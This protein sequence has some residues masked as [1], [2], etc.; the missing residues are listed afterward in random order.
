MQSKW[1]YTLVPGLLLG[2]TGCPDITV[3][4]DEVGT[5][6]PIVEFDPGNRIVPFPNNLLLDPTTGKVN[7]PASCNESPASMATRTMVLN[8]LDGFGTYQTAMSVTFSE[9][10]DAATLADHVV[11]YKRVAQ[12][13]PTDPAAATAVPVLTLPGTTTRFAADCASTAMVDSLTIVPLAPL[14]QRSTYTVGLLAGIKTA[15][16]ADY[17][18]SFTWALV[19]QA[20][21][22]V[23][24]DAAGNVVADTT[25]LDPRDEGDRA[26]LLGVNQLWKA[27]K[28]ALDF[29][30]AAGHPRA[31]V[32]LGWE[33]NTQTTMNPLDPMVA[34]S[35]AAATPT[36]PLVGPLSVTCN[37]DAITCP[38]GFDRSAPPFAQCSGGDTNV[39]CFLKVALGLASGASGTAIYPTGNAVCA[40][41]DPSP[42]GLVQPCSSIGDV[43]GG[44]LVAPQYQ[45]D[46]ANAFDATKPIPGP[47][48]NPLAPAAVKDEQIPVLAFVPAGTPPIDGWPTVV[49][50]HGLGSSKESTFVISPQLARAGYITVAIDFVAHGARA[51]QVTADAA[52]ACTGTPSA[53]L[54]PQCFAPFLSPNL[55][56]T[57]DNI[58][59]SVLDVLRL[60]AALKACD[61]DGCDAAVPTFSVDPTKLEY[62]GISLGGIMGSVI[63]AMSPDL[64]ASVLNVAGAGWADIFENTG[65]LAIQ[66]SLVNGLIDAGVLVGDK[67]NATLTT[68]L[69]TTPA[70][71][72]QAGYRQF[73]AIARWVLDPADPAN[74]NTR[75]AAKKFLLQEVI[76]DTVVP[77][78]ATDRLG[79]L[80]ATTVQD[81]D[82]ATSAG[83][84]ASAAITTMP[85]VKKWLK[86]TDVPANTGVG[87]PGNAFQHA[88]LLRPVSGPSPLDLAGQLGTVRLQVDAIT[89]L[90][91]NR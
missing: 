30:D 49:F 55:A 59:Q 21:N 8:Q 39:Q 68:G 80:T 43:V 50:G 44:V 51:K 4:P 2:A 35:P 28:G 90:V 33:F 46:T 83:P 41:L 48:A 54:S 91:L 27:H 69:C 84:A 67:S 63:T 75:L 77:N 38:L 86:Y 57:R 56:G 85:G 6:G 40:A 31:D 5:A 19:R 58:R 64:K 65:S 32:V 10:V 66:C 47:W 81:A 72:A 37:F 23:T 7:L 18:P 42:G 9:P 70:W 52:L 20:T 17:G 53:T 34:G 22:P 45:V 88:S 24:V 14:E 71:K 1:L 73:S 29:L 3:D 78:L 61:N 15:S 16:G 25:P 87:F 12:G 26:S 79:A 76:G 62:A 82:V 13:T 60:V 89:Y 74:F 11:L 36:T